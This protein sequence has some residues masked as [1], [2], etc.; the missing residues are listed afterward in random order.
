M[1]TTLVGMI[2]VDPKQLLQEGIRKELVRY[3]SAVLLA[4]L[5]LLRPC[6]AMRG[7]D[8]SRLVWPQTNGHGLARHAHLSQRYAASVRSRVVE[9]V[10][11]SLMQSMDRSDVETDWDACS[12]GWVV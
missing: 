9:D 1:E 12:S 10:A 3:Q 8:T 6:H 4:F 11:D 7:A 5:V 2:E